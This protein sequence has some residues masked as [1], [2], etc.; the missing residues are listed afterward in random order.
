MIPIS[1]V[2]EE[3]AQQCESEAVLCKEEGDEHAAAS[4]LGLSKRIRALAAK[5]EGCVVADGEVVMTTPTMRGDKPL[6]R[7]KEPTK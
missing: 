4:C 3:A 2:L 5:Y 6:Y 7:A 1:E